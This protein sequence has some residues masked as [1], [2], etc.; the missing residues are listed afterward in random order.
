[1][2]SCSL[3]SNFDIKTPRFR[4]VHYLKGSGALQLK[5]YR[6]L[7][8]NFELTFRFTSFSQHCFNNIWQEFWLESKSECLYSFFVFR[9]QNNDHKK[10]EMVPVNYNATW[11]TQPSAFRIAKWTEIQ[12][13]WIRNFFAK[14]GKFLSISKLHLPQIREIQRLTSNNCPLSC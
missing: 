14:K 8:F 11:E 5:L 12:G 3:P 1:M 4:E 7:T 13:K 6:T 9:T 10:M 2:C